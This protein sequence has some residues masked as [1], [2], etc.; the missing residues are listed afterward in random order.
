VLLFN[1]Y[2]LFDI[3][4]IFFELLDYKMSHLEFY[5]VVSG[6]TAVILS[7]LGKLWSWPIG[8]INVILAGFFYYQ[9]QLYPDMFLQVFF[10][11]TNIIGWWRWANPKPEEEDKKN[12]LRVSFMKPKQFFMICLSGIVGTF[13]VGALASRLHD[14][15]PVLFNLPSAYPYADSFILVMSIITTFF[16]IQKKI[17]CWIIWIIV[18]VVATYL[19]FVKGASFFAVEYFLFTILASFG[20]VNWI[21]E[22]RS[23]QKAL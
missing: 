13:F 14:W 20:L 3:N 18:D 21:K 23:Y 2:D 7:A 5:A 19:Y 4:S 12:E 8:I 22:Y 1:L 6:V 10:F 17:E 15:F 16:M 11:V 9:I